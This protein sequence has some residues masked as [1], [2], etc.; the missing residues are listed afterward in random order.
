MLH[1]FRKKKRACPVREDTREWMDSAFSWL[2]DAFGHDLF[3]QKKILIPDDNDFP[4]RYD[5]SHQSAIN[6][7]KIVAKQM[8]VDPESI[9]LKFYSE[10]ISEIDTG[11]MGRKIF[12][13]HEKNAK[14]SSGI[15]HGMNDDG[16]YDISLEEKNLKDPQGLVATLAHEIAHIK[17]L[18]EE[19][20]DK[21][22]EHLTDLTT[23]I[24]GLGIFNANM[25]F[26][27]NAGFDSWAYRKLGY[28][29]QIEWGFA[30]A[31]YAHL[32]GE[33]NPSWIKYLSDTV[34]GTFKRS[35]RFL[36]SDK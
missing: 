35:E 24:F 14:L 1:L 32:R 27:F 15:Y 10:G 6:T 4:V 18:G 17:L 28:L 5:G 3:S 34:K 19:R 16:K 12:I 33:T 13:D 8:D 30:L 22:N 11:G 21:N 26:R 25:A 31:V 29:T 20:L 2:I 36:V 9:L 7:L 23:I